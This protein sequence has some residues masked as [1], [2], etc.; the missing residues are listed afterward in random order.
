MVI[1]LK[2]NSKIPVFVVEVYSAITDSNAPYRW[3]IQKTKNGYRSLMASFHRASTGSQ[4][5]NSEGYHYGNNTFSA[6]GYASAGSIAVY[7]SV[8][9]V[10]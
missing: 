8:L 4:H 1:S 9:W 2:L 5:C 3:S 10:K 7:T 6:E